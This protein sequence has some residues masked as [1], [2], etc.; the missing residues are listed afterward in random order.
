MNSRKSMNKLLVSVALISGAFLFAGCT[1]V[2]NSNSNVSNV[3]ARISAVNENVNTSAS[4][5]NSVT[6]ES[7][8]KDMDT[9]KMEKKAV[10]KTNKGVMEIGLYTEKAP[11]T[12]QNF[13][14]LIEKDFYNGLIFHRV[15]KDFMIQGGDPDGVG[16]GGPGYKIEDE[17]DPALSHSKK[18]VLSMANS[19]PNTGGSQFF[20]TL[21][22]T[23]WLDGKHAV[24]GEVISGIEVLEAIGATET[25]FQDKPAEDII[26]ESVTVEDNA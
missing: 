15:I 2:G 1:S 5:T 19:G 20:V 4:N 8:K 16:T 23:P 12:T 9:G 17:F 21:I 18:G 7:N 10:I 26:M 6:K 24:F 14:D 25:G 11:I 3:N 13:I 22:E